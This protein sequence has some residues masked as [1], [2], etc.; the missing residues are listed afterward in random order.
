MLVTQT[1]SPRARR[2]LNGEGF[3]WRVPQ[4]S[5]NAYHRQVDL[6]LD[7]VSSSSSSMTLQ[8]PSRLEVEGL[9]LEVFFGTR[10]IKDPANEKRYLVDDLHFTGQETAKFSRLM[11]VLR[12]WSSRVRAWRYSEMAEEDEEEEDDEDDEE[13]EAAAAVAVARAPTEAA[14]GVEGV[15]EDEELSSTSSSSLAKSIT[16]SQMASSI[17]E[18]TCCDEQ[19]SSDSVL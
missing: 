19:V 4:A 16:S 6:S 7:A 8:L 11:T 12:E 5:A 15:D 14:K 9:S 17:T 1:L 10:E 13:E 18:D 3:P 2:R